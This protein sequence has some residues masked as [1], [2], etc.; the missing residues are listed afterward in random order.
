RAKWLRYTAEFFEPAY[1]QPARRLAQRAVVLQDL[2][3]DFQHGVRGPGASRG[4]ECEAQ[5]GATIRKNVGPAVRA[6]RR[7]G[8]RPLRRAL[9]RR[10]A[11]SEPVAAVEANSVASRQNGV[12]GR[13]VLDNRLDHIT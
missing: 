1:G 9:G 11:G 6:V 7:K 13:H 4:G 10:Q 2:L 12:K 3:G 8:W 5:R